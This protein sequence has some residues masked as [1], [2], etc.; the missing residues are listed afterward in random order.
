MPET[1]QDPGL[2]VHQQQ[3]RCG[4]VHNPQGVFLNRRYVS[5]IIL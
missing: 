5:E 3:A 2:C 1:Y 4:Q